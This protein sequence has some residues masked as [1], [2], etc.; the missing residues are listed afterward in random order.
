MRKS[1]PVK[2]SLMLVMAFALTGCRY[3]ANRCADF[4]DIFQFGV[5]VTIENPKTGFAPPSLGVHAQATEF[6]NLSAMHFEGK[7]AEWDGRGFFAGPETRTRFGLG[8]WQRLRIDQNYKEGGENYFK[9]KDA[10]W[11][12][13]LNKRVNRWWHKPAKEL[14]YEFWANPA[15]EGWPIMHRGYQYWE[16][17][18]VEVCVSEP[19]ITHH[20]LALRLGFDPSEIFD[21]LGGF[22][23]YDFK[24]DD[25]TPEEY[26]EMK[27]GPRPAAPEAPVA[28]ANNGVATDN[29]PVDAPREGDHPTK[30]P[31]MIPGTEIIYFDYDRHNIRKDQLDRAEKNLKFLK[32]HP[33]VRAIITGYCDERGT[34]EYNMSLGEKRAQIVRDYMIKGGI[35]A[36]R[37]KIQSKGEE[38]PADPGHDESAW[39][40]NRRA[41]FM[42]FE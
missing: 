12:Q 32:D 15:H 7:S 3:G 4:R 35:D 11:T 10:L 34:S 17:I 25:L 9:K 6:I 2:G 42:S 23:M 24:R 16:N 30:E 19:F 18:G 36:N 5:G 26:D 37:L 8:P 20:G 39:A 21:W 1:I 28:P 38:E 31:Q 33:D 14:E 41:V 40:K 29:R 27:N 22:F 13:R